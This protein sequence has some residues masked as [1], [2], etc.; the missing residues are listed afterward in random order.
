MRQVESQL[1]EE[2]LDVVH[3]DASVGL[4]IDAPYFLQLGRRSITYRRYT[5]SDLS[6]YIYTHTHTHTHIYIYIYMYIYICVY[7]YICMY[8]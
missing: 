2:K 6:I 5:I 8:V 4:R 3:V 7:I 1:L